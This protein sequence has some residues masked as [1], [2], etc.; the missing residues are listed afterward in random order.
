MSENTG[1][2]KKPV[3]RQN[4]EDC[5]GDRAAEIQLRLTKTK[6]ILL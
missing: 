6:N 3:L 4:D 2:N 5:F 1:D